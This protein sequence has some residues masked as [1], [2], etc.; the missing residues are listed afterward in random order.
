[1]RMIVDEDRINCPSSDLLDVLSGMIGFQDALARTKFDVKRMTGISTLGL[2]PVAIGDCG[3]SR[4]VHTAVSLVSRPT[5]LDSATRARH[6]SIH[7]CT[8]VTLTI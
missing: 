7:G 2:Y 6:A 4:W 5:K 3:A 8:R 1:M